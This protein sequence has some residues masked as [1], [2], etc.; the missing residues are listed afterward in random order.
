[1][2]SATIKPVTLSGVF[3]NYVSF[4][5]TLPVDVTSMSIDAAGDVVG[6][7][8]DAA[9]QFGFIETG[10]TFSTINVLGNLATTAN[11]TAA[12]VIF[13]TYNDAAGAPHGFVD[14]GGTFSTFAISITGASSINVLGVDAA[15]DVVGTYWTSSSPVQQSFIVKSGVT[16]TIAA[17]NAS[18]TVVTGIDAVGDVVG[19]YTD[20]GGVQHG[21]VDKS[22]VFSTID[23]PNANSTIVLGVDAAGDVFGYYNDNVTGA[24]RGF[25]DKNGVISTID[26][27]NGSYTNVT[28]VDAAGD[29]FGTYITSAGVDEG[30][31]DRGGVFSTVAAPNAYWTAVLGIDAAGGIVGNYD[32]IVNS[33]GTLHY[34][35]EKNGV[36]ST[37]SSEGPA[38]TQL[39]GVNSAG[40]AAYGSFSNP[41]T[42]SGFVFVV[43]NGA[44]W[45][46][47]VPFVGVHLTGVD[48]AGDVV[49]DYINGSGDGFPQGFVDKNGVF[50]TINAPNAIETYVTGID[51]A[52]DIFGYYTDIYGGGQHGFIDKNGVFSAIDAPNAPLTWVTGVD[53]AGDVVGNY[54]NG[55]GVQHGFID[56]SGAISTIDAP[57]ASSTTVTG[58]DAAGDVF[59]YYVDSAGLPH[60]FVDKSG[61]ISTIGVPTSWTAAGSNIPAAAVVGIDTAGDVFG[62]YTDS[63]GNQ[64]SFIDKNGVISTID[65]P[66]ASSTVIT[67]V[68]AAGGVVGYYTD[69]TGVQH[70]LGP[71]SLNAAGSSLVATTDTGTTTVAAGHL[72]TISLTTDSAAT[73]TGTPTLQLNDNEVATYTGGSGTTTLTFTYIVQPGDGSPDLQVTGLNLTA[74]ATIQ[75]AAGDNLLNV[76]GDL[77][78]HVNGASSP[79]PTTVQQDVMGLYA[80]IFGRA[81][82]Y[83]GYAYWV[84]ADQPGV[85]PGNAGTTPVTM[86]ASMA[87]ADGFLAAAPAYFTQTYGAMTDTQFINAVYLNLGGA[88]ADPGGLAYWTGVLAQAETQSQSILAARA[89]VVGE[90]VDIMVGFNVNI[91]PA[92]FTDQQWADVLTR[93]ETIDNKITVSIA[94]AN[95][96]NQP[97]GN[98]LVPQTDSDAA[99]QAATTVLHGVTSDPHTVAIALAGIANAVAHQNLALI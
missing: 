71:A 34:Y 6:T 66:N 48:A 82:E 79:P 5:T 26:V 74:G 51:A 42:F 12:G 93:Q 73:V 70:A 65:A 55:D 25:V 23:A 87:M 33:A 14:I 60:L 63:S 41:G 13:G 28:G 58:V 15:G 80:A 38:D 17:P 97:G 20:S 84:S 18:S 57:N 54:G 50:S 67:G 90:I 19:N 37:L 2:P 61:V 78:L 49:G 95:A 56:K 8:S 96:S 1:M 68:D 62:N 36:F 46:L 3:G 92:G 94:Y 47:N 29:I 30:F 91:R 31:V 45:A 24:E 72:V 81:A 16:S 83:S 10:G 35:I 52:G 64:H 7:Y 75:N 88:A 22:G 77:G 27:P 11:I 69:G 85:T 43:E 53:A 32:V 89:T 9:G 40:T 99:A 21:F 59:G 86:A 98:I 76:A 44:L 4:D 39:L